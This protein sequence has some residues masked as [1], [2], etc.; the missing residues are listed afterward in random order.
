MSTFTY[1]KIGQYGDEV[2]DYIIAKDGILKAK[3]GKDYRIRI[4]SKSYFA[5]KNGFKDKI[6][7]RQYVELNQELRKTQFEI[8]EW[9]AD[10]ISADGRLKDLK[11]KTL[12]W[13]QLEKKVFSSKNITID[14]PQQEKISL[15]IFEYVLGSRTQNWRSFDEMFR[16]GED[17]NGKAVSGVAKIFPELNKLPDWWAHF[18]LQFNEIKEATDLPNN[19]FD[20][21][22]Y[23]GKGSFMK[24]ISDLVV[25]EMS[26]YSQKDSWN[27]A[28]IWLIQTEKIKQHYI[29][30]FN[31]IS[32][33]CK[34]E[35]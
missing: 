19:K 20:V 29:K 15:K 17:R 21:Y 18:T 32:K 4:D 16:A 35:K 27:P 3:N 11:Y 2:K 7:K 12:G 23:D 6:E 13:T 9:P 1:E 30:E 26:L 31:G 25:K 14:T 33:N 5:R 34:M 28:D 8:A 10:A 24:Y 22:Q